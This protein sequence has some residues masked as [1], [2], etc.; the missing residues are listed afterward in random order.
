MVTLSCASYP[1][2]YCG[3]QNMTYL[4][5][6][7]A[8]AIT[9]TLLAGIAVIARCIT[10]LQLTNTLGV[11][12]IIIVV[13]FLGSAGLATLICLRMEHSPIDQKYLFLTNGDIRDRAWLSRKH[14]LTDERL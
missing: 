6:S 4:A 12:E 11:E 3:K 8:F 5:R 9:P 7:F 13:A 14:H 10:R 1:R 2:E